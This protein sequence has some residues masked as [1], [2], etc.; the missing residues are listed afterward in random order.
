MKS[1]Y[2]LF[3]LVFIIVCLFGAIRPV[4][5]VEPTHDDFLKAWPVTCAEP[6]MSENGEILVST[7]IDY[8]SIDLVAGQVR[9][10]GAQPLVLGLGRLGEGGAHDVETRL[11]HLVGARHLLPVDVQVALHL[12]QPLD[13]LLFGPQHGHPPYQY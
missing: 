11:H 4:H 3:F 12:A 9:D 10:R 2:G 6:P 1:M 7:Q 13:V 5:A 8:Y